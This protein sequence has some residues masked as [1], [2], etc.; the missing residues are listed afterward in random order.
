[1]DTPPMAENFPKRNRIVSGLS[2]G[3]LV[4]EAD[5]RSGALITARQAGVDQGR[6]VFAL[7]GRVDNKLSNGPH[8]LIRDGAT[9]VTRLEDILDD[10]GPL[11]VEAMEES[12]TMLP[13]TEPVAKPETLSPPVDLSPAQEILLQHLGTDPVGIDAIMDRTELDASTVMR[14]L[15]YLSLK[16]LVKR[17]D[18]QTYRRSR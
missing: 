9:L 15:T 3:V 8:Q 6:P 18:G 14:E 16:G 11:P 5:E 10:L 4:V 17:G 12:I 2:R 1:M 7:P 13:I